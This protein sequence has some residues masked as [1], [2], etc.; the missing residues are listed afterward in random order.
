MRWRSR[1]WD[2]SVA[3]VGWATV[4]CGRSSIPVDGDPA[5]FTG[6]DV[7]SSEVVPDCRPGEPP[8]ELTAGLALPLGIVLT[9][10]AVFFTDYDDDGGVYCVPKAGGQLEPLAK[11]LDHA[12]Q[13]L[14]DDDRI[15]VTVTREDRIVAIP[16]VGGALETVTDGQRGVVGIGIDEDHLYWTNYAGNQ[17]RRA[18]RNAEDVLTIDTESPGRLGLSDGWIYFARGDTKLLSVDKTANNAI[19]LSD[20]APQSFAS[21]GAVVFWTSRHPPSVRVLEEAWKLDTV[22]A[23]PPDAQ[24]D[25]VAYDGEYVYW[26]DSRGPIQRRSRNEPMAGNPAIET[27][28]TDPGRPMLLAV[29]DACVYWT[30]YDPSTG[31]GRVMRGSKVPE[32][33]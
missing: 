4:A 21:A 12:N 11:G 1:L 29:D 10:H 17:F 5:D 30:S 20:V 24:P 32:G 7:C 31:S 19:P 6:H 2:G 23:L 8:V 33:P 3:L 18:D 9:E 27:I 13:L 26:V 14:I 22:A 28:A 15:L 16:L 25:G